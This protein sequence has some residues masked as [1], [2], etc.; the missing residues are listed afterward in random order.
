M[1]AAMKPYLVALL[2]LPAL[3]SAEVPR[4][5]LTVDEAVGIDEVTR[6]VTWL[7]ADE[8]QG[9]GLGTEGL[10]AAANMIASQFET[11]GLQAFEA[12]GFD[13]YFQEFDLPFSQGFDPADSS[14]RIGDRELT[15]TEDFMPFG[16]SKA[17][18]FE[19]ELVFAGYGISREDYDDY[20]GLDVAGKVALILR[21]E[22]FEEDGRSRFSGSRG[23]SRDAGFR[24]KMAA[25]EA[26]G[27]KALLVV[28]PPQHSRAK[29]LVRASSG[30]TLGK[31]P[32]MHVT[33]ETAD[34][35]L[36]EA[37]LPEVAELQE[38][39]DSTGTPASMAAKNGVEITGGWSDE[40]ME[41]R[42]R[43]VVAY[44]PGSTRPDEFVVVG[45]HYDHVGHGEYGSM[46][47]GEVH[48]GAD[49][50]ASGTTAVMEIAEAL[51]TA[52]KDGRGPERSVAF[53]LFSAEEV[54]LIGSQHFVDNAPID[55][56]QMVAMVNLDMVGRVREGEIFVGGYGT[57]LALASAAPAA[58]SAAGLILRPDPEGLEARS[59][60]APF[61]AVDIPAI[62]FFSG[63]HDQYHRPED[64]AELINHEGLVRVT[65]AGLAVVR[66]AA[67]APE[68]ALA[69][70][71]PTRPVLLG[72][73]LAG[74]N[75][76]T[77]AGVVPGSFA[78]S[79]G[80]QEGDKIL[81]V[82]N[83]EVETILELR[84]QL[85]TF[86][87]GDEATLHVR[88]G[89]QRVTSQGRFPGGPA[90]RRGG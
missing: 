58:V 37:G 15:A 59:D 40:S 49:D 74:G 5:L 90:T 53:V 39:I 56:R 87:A 26:A 21:Y 9:R 14:L 78:A 33:Q 19:G 2:A 27:A 13:G 8:R 75:D 11:L 85:D 82:G 62:Y 66:A 83:A 52:A 35:L 46:V 88:R 79:A 28:N 67:A 43:N 51:A 25:A 38:R 48:N 60:H 64:D 17:D 70:V 1:M 80:V 89:E 12:D 47:P 18:D 6:H 81:A 68:A 30:M 16:W 84:R 42:V 7:S 86:Q 50:N 63:F 61:L 4:E 54:G 34:A 71:E 3:A 55:V 69:W 36:G 20:E 76:L 44:L 24:R 32:A 65:R 77:I 23:F 72:V 45:A 41:T 73:Q 10:D 31:I 57:S 29:G 22:P